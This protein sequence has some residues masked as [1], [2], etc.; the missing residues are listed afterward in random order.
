MNLSLDGYL[1]RL[2]QDI[3][4]FEVRVILIGLLF[5]TENDTCEL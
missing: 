1:L 2:R 4:S 3:D 5:A